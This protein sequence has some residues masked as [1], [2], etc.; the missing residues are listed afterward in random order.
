MPYRSDSI[1]STKTNFDE[2]AEKEFFRML[3]LAMV[4]NMPL[5]ISGTINKDAT[6]MFK[7]AK[8]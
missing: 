1:S 3:L 5:H 8:K 4:L 6:E 7:R 2:L